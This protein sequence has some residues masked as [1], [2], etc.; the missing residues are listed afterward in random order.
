MFSNTLVELTNR[1][2]LHTH[3]L[4][5]LAVDSPPKTDYIIKKLPV[6]VN[7]KN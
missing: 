1:W 2:Y 6:S 4:K 7:V 3:M 5:I